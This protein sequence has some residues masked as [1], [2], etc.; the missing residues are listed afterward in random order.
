MKNKVT[1]HS[2]HNLAGFLYRGGTQKYLPP[3]FD[4]YMY[5]KHQSLFTFREPLPNKTQQPPKE[6]KA[7]YTWP[8][9]TL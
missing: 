4:N 3:E 2:C 8:S 9:A 5:T 6:S 1:P 7:N